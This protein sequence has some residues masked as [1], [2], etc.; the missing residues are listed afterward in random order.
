ME[1]KKNNALE[2]AQNLERGKKSPKK[3]KRKPKKSSSERARLKEERSAEKARIKAEKK[4]ELERIKAHRQAEKEKAKNARKRELHKLREAKKAEKIKRKEERLKRKEMLKNESRKDREKRLREER[5]VRIENKKQ[6]AL[7]KRR[8]RE[9][10]AKERRERRKQNK[11]LGGWITAVLSLGVATLVLSSVLTYN[12]LMPSKS[13]NALEQAYQRSFYDTVEHVENVDLNLSKFFATKDNEARQ[14]YLVDTAI[15]AEL[16][17]LNLSELPLKDESR[18]YTSKLINQIGDYSKYLNE[19]LVKGESLSEEETASLLTLYEENKTLKNSLIEM[20]NEMDKD[21]TFANLS[22]QDNA[23]L[24][25]FNSLQ[26]LSVE[27]PELIYDGPFSDGLN[28]REVK[29][30][31]GA[32]INSNQAEDIFKAIFANYK[33]QN[34]KS[35][36]ETNGYLECFNVQGETNGDILYAQISKVGGKLIM[37]SYAGS[38]QNISIDQADAI[39]IATN[40]IKEQDIEN[41]AEV[42]VNLSHNTYTINFAFTQNGVIVYSDLIKVR[43]CA[44]TGKVIGYEAS[45]YYTN[46]TDRVIDEPTISLDS[47]KE[48]VSSNIAIDTERLVVVPFGKQSERLCYEFS[49]EYDGSIFYAYIDAKTGKQVELFKVIEGSEGSL[50]M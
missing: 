6:R 13:D 32:S 24:E 17:E 1:E 8:I 20:M 21:F 44:E 50:L 33:L 35:E 39:E 19:K 31:T 36:G 2:K 7:E 46:H 49:G 3:S 27:Y 28:D 29:G 45:S 41:M 5:Q 30:L 4:V 23:L 11:G 18:F 9:E 40:F 25:R 37:F 43:V 42:W 22:E 38:C 16:A 47:A 12:F 15:N 26:N 34:V 10:K 48:S 14:L